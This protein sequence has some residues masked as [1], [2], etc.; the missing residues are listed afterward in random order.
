METT[1]YGFLLPSLW[2]WVKTL[3]IMS[4]GTLISFCISYI[5]YTYIIPNREINSAKI[6][7]IGFGVLIP[8]MLVLPFIFVELFQIDNIIQS[9]GAAL[10]MFVYPLRCSEAMFGF[11]PKYVETT[12]KSYWMYFTCPVEVVFDK[13]GHPSRASAFDI[14]KR[15]RTSISGFLLVGFLISYLQPK[16]FVPFQLSSD[17][18]LNFDAEANKYG[19]KKFAEL[20][21][22]RR[23]TNNFI[24]AVLTNLC[25][26]AGTHF[27]A[28]ANGLVGGI[29]VIVS[30]STST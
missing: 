27:I 4:I 1:K 10:F 25:L 12:F 15:L 7:L 3:F 17:L 29:N 24:M 8:S 30:L 2:F 9:F 5:I 21:N 11:S 23:L 26:C 13:N 14:Q 6:N 16:D 28:A 20:F 18:Q 19:L 22:V